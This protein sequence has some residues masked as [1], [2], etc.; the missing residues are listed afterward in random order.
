[1]KQARMVRPRPSASVAALAPLERR[2]GCGTCHGVT[3][4][5]P[6]IALDLPGFGTS[7]SNGLARNDVVKQA[8]EFPSPGHQ[9][10][11]HLHGAKGDCFGGAVRAQTKSFSIERPISPQ[12][13]EKRPLPEPH[14]PNRRRQQHQRGS[15][16]PW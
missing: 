10:V 8:R 2:G 4:F 16:A 11:T 7:E 6:N 1:M 15:P 14:G 5:R 9:S 3:L 12:T 13:V